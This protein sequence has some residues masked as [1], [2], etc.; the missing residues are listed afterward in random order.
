MRRIQVSVPDELYDEIKRR[1]L[2]VSQLLELAVR[3]EIEQHEKNDSLRE[4]L[5]ELTAEVGEPSAEALAR[6]DAMALRIRTR[7]LAEVS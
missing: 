6:A 4:Y 5:K 7:R 1:K 3:V 2:P